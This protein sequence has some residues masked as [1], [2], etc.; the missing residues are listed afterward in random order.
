MG[1]TRK[2][3]LLL[4]LIL[5]PEDSAHLRSLGAHFGAQHPQ[6]HAFIYVIPRLPPSLFALATWRSAGGRASSP[7]VPDGLQTVLINPPRWM[8][9]RRVGI[10]RNLFDFG[11]VFQPSWFCGSLKIRPHK[12]KKLPCNG[13]SWW[14]HSGG[15]WWHHRDLPQT[16]PVSHY[17]EA[18]GT[19]CHPHGT[20]VAKR[21][22]LGSVTK[23]V[24]ARSTSHGDKLGEQ[25][26]SILWGPE[27]LGSPPTLLLG[28]GRGRS[29]APGGRG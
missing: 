4:I 16:C 28:L 2:R 22:N 6:E 18:T 15:G 23:M 21:V 11:G 10:R 13:P 5:L 12:G 25:A 7:S 26:S 27:A 20:F 19:K 17:E 14:P 3:R 1:T 24:T 29:Q 9:S 8:G